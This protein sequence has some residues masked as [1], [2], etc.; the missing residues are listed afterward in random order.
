M[1]RQTPAYDYRFRRAIEQIVGRER[2]L[3]VWHHHWC[4]EG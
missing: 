4:G 3:R 1:M 2:R